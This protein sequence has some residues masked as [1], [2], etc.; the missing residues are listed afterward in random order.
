MKKTFLLSFILLFLLSSLVGCAQ[1]MPGDAKLTDVK[2]TTVTRAYD[3]G[4]SI[5]KVILCFDTQ[6]DPASFD[7]STFIVKSN[8]L[9]A[10]YNKAKAK[11]SKK[12]YEHIVEREITDVYISDIE[13]NQSDTGNCISI[14]MSVGPAIIEA[15]PYNY[16]YETGFTEIID[17]SYEI[18]LASD[19]SIQS[20]DGEK[21]FFYTTGAE[22]FAGDIK[23]IADDFVNNQ[24]F[25][26]SGINMTY[27]YYQPEA[28]ADEG[29]V[30]IIIWLHGGGEGGT[31]TTLVLNSNEVVNLATEP[32]QA[33]FGENGAYVLAPQ[34]PTMWMDIDGTGTFNYWVYNSHG[35]S[36]YTEALMALIDEF[37]NTHSDIDTNRI[38]LGGCS[39]GG[40]MTVNMLMEYPDY[41]AAAFPVCPAYWKPWMSNEKIEAIKDI[42]IWMTH[43]LTDGTVPIAQGEIDEDAELYKVKYASDGS[44]FLTD[45]YSNAFYRKLIDAGA[46]NV[47][48]S[49]FDSVVDTSGLYTNSDGTPYEY[50]GHYSWIYVFNNECIETIDGVEITIFEWLGQQRKD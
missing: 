34:V 30:P 50:W 15:S 42:P 37:V 26:Y 20:A 4:A 41:F 12:A 40:Y 43:A 8:R 11:I 46:E 31:E 35:A 19:K 33:Y 47:Y 18:S 21:L 48:Y 29:S 24:K 6:I 16:N 3:W 49:R 14:E 22:E 44:P 1:K 36:Y 39:S 2:Y 9:C 5:D 27:A 25:S 7:A 10:D 28:S 17:T 23:I 38:Y 13:G 45:E 32:Y